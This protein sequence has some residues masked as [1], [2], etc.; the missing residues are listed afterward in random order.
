M[1]RAD[2]GRATSP[3]AA[4]G[5]RVAAAPSPTPSP[6]RASPRASPRHGLLQARGGARRAQA[7]REGDAGH[8]VLAGLQ[9]TARPLRQRAARGLEEAAAAIKGVMSGS[10]LAQSAI[11]SARGGPE[12]EGLRGAALAGGLVVN[13]LMG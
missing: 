9:G 3:R 2:T 12:E 6:R 13:I 11:E 10:A 8:A 1:T 5:A 4:S 7:G